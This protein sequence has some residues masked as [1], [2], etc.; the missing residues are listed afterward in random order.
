MYKGPIKALVAWFVLGVAAWA[1]VPSYDLLLKGGHVLDPENDV[2]GVRDV[3]IRGDRIA[4]VEP[5]IPGAS[6]KKVIDVSGLYVSPG[7]VDIHA[8]FYVH[9]DGPGTLLEWSPSVI[10]DH[11]LFQAGVTTAVDA[12]TSGWR[13]FPD[14]RRRIV[15]PSKARVLAMLNIV[16]AGIVTFELEQNPHDMA[17]ERTAAMA[18]KH[19]DIVVGIK[20]AH[21]WA[22]DFTSVKQALEAGRL[23]EIPVMVDFG[24]FLPERPYQKMVLELFRP[25]DISTHFYRWP[26]PILDESEKLLPYLRK[27]R[28]RGV[29]FD[30]GHGTGSFHF[31]QAEPAVK[32]GFWPDSIST[33]LHSDSVNRSMIDM[34]NVMS[35]FL[36]MGMPLNEVIRRST[37]NPATM[38]KR[39]ELGQI[40]VG[41]E[42]DVAVLRL[43]RGKYGFVDVLN[44]RI[45]GTQRLG[46]E[47]TIRAGEIVFDFNGRAGV[48]WRRADIDY[49]TR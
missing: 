21:W 3:A 34:L 18:R 10:P 22:P 35:K 12:G 19:S 4:A 28:E 30:V 9:T 46:C 41:A 5:N 13:T 49:P 43:D 6:A 42:A 25:G 40:S 23:A 27:A 26:A 24:Y 8:H 17:P 47:M 45:E 38:I 15:D 7:L 39:P 11:H 33:D 20:S 32:A 48:A 44:G 31:R 16:G 37:T 2:D 1:Q 29:K 14:F 36:A